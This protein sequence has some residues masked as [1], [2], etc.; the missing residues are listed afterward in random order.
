MYVSS[1]HQCTCVALSCARAAPLIASVP[2]VCVLHA[3]NELCVLAG[4]H[5]SGS[6]RDEDADL[7]E[8]IRLSLLEL[9]N[10]ARDS[11]TCV[12]VCVVHV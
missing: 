7:A 4:R 11:G 9:E 2:T 6:L 8:A 1:L 5:S 10:A 3:T 12:C